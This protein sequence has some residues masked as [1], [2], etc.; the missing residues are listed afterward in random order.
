MTGEAL[1]GPLAGKRLELYNVLHTTAGQVLAQDPAT[2]VAI[3][4]HPRVA[5]SGPPGGAGVRSLGRRVG[6]WLSRLTNLGERGLSG[7][8]MGTIREE[9]DRRPTMELGIGI[10]DGSAA[11]YYAMPTVEEH[12]RALLDTFEG[13]NVLVY[14]D[15][16]AYA[17]IAHYT[18]ADRVW[19][20]DKVLHLST[21]E[22]IENGLLF[23]EAGDEVEADSPLQVF[24]RWYGFSLTFP[25]TEVYE[26][27]REPL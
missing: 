14:Y 23:N 15:P 16:T 2:L 9:D 27:S 20:E 4:E 5:L 25:E 24:T 7:Q 18:T 22:R 21:G 8:F 26:G 3:S 17:L 1:Y 11:R 10:W 12:G 6:T 19:W 13:R